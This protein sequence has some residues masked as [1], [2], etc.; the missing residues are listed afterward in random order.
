MKK[1]IKPVACFIF[2]LVVYLLAYGQ[3]NFTQTLT[4]HVD[5]KGSA[6]VEMTQKMNAQQWQA[7]KASVN[8]SNM[9]VKKRDI[10]RM[11]PM[12]VL[13]NFKY[14]EDE[15]ERT[16]KFTFD[17]DGFAEYTGDNKW[18]I[19]L[20]SKKPQIEKLSDN[21]YML[22]STMAT[23]DGGVFQQIHKVYFPSKAS[24]VEVNKDAFGMAKLDYN[25]K[26]EKGGVP[27]MLI[28]GGILTL[29]GAGLFFV[30][31]KKPS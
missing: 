22:T 4:Y 25:L 11:L 13:R 8:A 14:S 28:G 23:I 10:E 19:K 5:D 20:E 31:K 2:S 3:T 27:L 16:S 26:S 15:M 21:A 17:V 1:I 18:T 12:L 24:S 29:A 6:A 30:Q 9:A 7:F